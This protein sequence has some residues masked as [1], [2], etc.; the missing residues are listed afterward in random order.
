MVV[1]VQRETSTIP[2]VFA[3]V[4]DPIGSGFVTSLARPVGNLTG[5]I[6]FEASIVGKWLSMLKEI[7]PDVVRAVL[8]GNPKTSPFDYFLKAPN[9]S[10]LVTA[11]A[12]TSAHRN[13][14]IGLAAQHRLPAVY[15]FRIFVTDGGLMSYAVDIVDLVR[16]TRL[17]S[18]SSYAARKRPTFLFKRRPNTK[19][20][21][22]S[23]PRKHSA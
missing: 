11:D 10:I 8:I 3:G 14:I 12:T 4:S 15:P 21:S 19:Q 5:L 22:I 23:K 7:A 18:T 17:T 2:I 9:G 1:A 16:K 20:F 13:V 6:S